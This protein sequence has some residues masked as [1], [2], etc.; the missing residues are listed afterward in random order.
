MKILLLPF[1]GTF[2]FLTLLLFFIPQIICLLICYIIAKKKGY[3]SW[4]L[5]L[6]LLGILG[7]IIMIILPNEVVYDEKKQQY[8]TFNKKDPFASDFDDRNYRNSNNNQFNSKQEEER[9]YYYNGNTYYQNGEKVEKEYKK[10]KH[11]GASLDKKA[12]FCT[13]CGR[14]V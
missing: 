5:L 8:N 9:T 7:I 13:Y 6:G 14:D 4:T 3:P 12:S 11:C 10:C 2:Y 1:A